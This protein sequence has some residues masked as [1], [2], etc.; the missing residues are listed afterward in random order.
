MEETYILPPLRDICRKDGHFWIVHS[1]RL[2]AC[3][4]CGVDKNEAAG[5]R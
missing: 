4:R 3:A 5:E 1:P 2:T